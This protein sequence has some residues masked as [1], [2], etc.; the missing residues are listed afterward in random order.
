MEGKRGLSASY[1]SE[2]QQSVW[3][4]YLKGH[5]WGKV[6]FFVPVHDTGPSLSCS[7]L[8]PNNKQPHFQQSFEDYVLQDW[9]QMYRGSRLHEGEPFSADFGCAKVAHAGPS[10]P[11]VSTDE[12][13]EMQH[14]AVRSTSS[15]H[16]CIWLHLSQISNVE[17]YL[18][19]YYASTG[20]TFTL[21]II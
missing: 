15:S 2:Q 10:G 18:I 12:R 16:V 8:A 17:D 9:L 11:G 13:P 3:N 21:N 4:L 14:P 5:G 1:K 6:A 19:Q 20:N 7:L